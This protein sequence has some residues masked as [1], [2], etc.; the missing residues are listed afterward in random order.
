LA[1]CAARRSSAL[2]TYAD[3]FE[4]LG[5]CD[6]NNEPVDPPVILGPY[7]EGVTRGRVGLFLSVGA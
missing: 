1:R 5:P 4:L 2:L 7:R 3:M 6:L